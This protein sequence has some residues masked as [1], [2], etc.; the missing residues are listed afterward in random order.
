MSSHG[1]RRRSFCFP[2]H[3]G[4]RCQLVLFFGLGTAENR[5]ELDQQKQKG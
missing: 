5:R 3:A 4:K 1:A 2:A